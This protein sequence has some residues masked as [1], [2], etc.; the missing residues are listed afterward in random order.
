[1]KGKRLR[2]LDIAKGIA[3]I[4]VVIGHAIPDASARQG[5]S[6]PALE[7]LFSVIY[8]FHMPLFFLISG[9][10]VDTLSAAVSRKQLIWKKFQ[11]L[12]IPYLFVGLA[13]APC[14]IIL[15]Q[16]ANDPFQA[17]NLWKMLIGVN[18]DGE[19]WFLYSLFVISAFAY[20]FR[21]KV[22][23]KWM[24][25]SCMMG[26]GVASLIHNIPG[27]VFFFQ[28]FFFLGLYIRQQNP[29][30]ID[31]ISTR[32]FLICIV[33][34]MGLN[35]PYYYGSPVFVK[36]LTGTFGSIAT[37]YISARLAKSDALLV[38]WLEIAGKYCMEIYILS[39]IVKIPIR[40]LLWSKL[41][42]YYAAFC[43]CTVADI[44][45]P[46]FCKK[47]LISRF[48]ILDFLLFGEKRK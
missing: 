43:V 47:Y 48:P 41:H 10:F 23:I 18:P 12:M 29:E 42:L 31:R 30:W 9:Y 26:G 38:R 21:A 17:A 1:M 7:I 22:G 15:S 3:I 45:L 46:V 13:Y 6:S 14:K 20:I 34:W 44:I 37:L 27:N 8:S 4:L 16:Y 5:I 25:G 33:L 40:I 36:L 2:S 24:I 19:L 28:F 39:D 32:T 35:V 11:R